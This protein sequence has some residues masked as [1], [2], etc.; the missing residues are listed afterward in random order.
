MNKSRKHFST[1][2]SEDNDKEL[3][4]MK[5]KDSVPHSEHTKIFFPLSTTAWSP[6]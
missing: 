4:G 5:M 3:E 1:F 6:K 2:F